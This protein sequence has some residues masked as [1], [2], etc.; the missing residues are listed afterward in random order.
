ME[1]PPCHQRASVLKSERG[2]GPTPRW[3]KR[4]AGA[5][6]R[7]ETSSGRAGI[8]NRGRGTAAI[9]TGAGAPRNVAADA[10]ERAPGAQPPPPP[11][12]VTP[13]PRQR[14]ITSH[15][16]EPVQRCSPPGPPHTI[17]QAVLLA[18]LGDA[19]VACFVPVSGP[20]LR[21]GSRPIGKSGEG[22][23]EFP[24]RMKQLTNQ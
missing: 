22:L 4:R 16:L 13:H 10:A 21:G 9:E 20:A 19:S 1:D 24:Q 7:A 2:R 11:A 12:E 5:T 18:A 17:V 15:S 3:G 14:R 23:G 8:R 6:T